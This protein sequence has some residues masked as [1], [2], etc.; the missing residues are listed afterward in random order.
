MGNYSK[1]YGSMGAIIILMVWLYLTSY[2]W[3]IGGEV[4]AIGNGLPVYEVKTMEQRMAGS[5]AP[6]PMPSPIMPNS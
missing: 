2:A 1:V 4:N 6:P 3:I 5:V